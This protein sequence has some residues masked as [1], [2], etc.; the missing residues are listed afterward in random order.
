MEGQRSVI[1]FGVAMKCLSILHYL[2]NHLSV[3]VTSHS[4]SGH[5]IHVKSEVALRVVVVKAFPPGNVFISHFVCKVKKELPVIQFFDMCRLHSLHHRA[6]AAL[7]LK[8][9]ESFV[10]L[11][12]ETIAT[13]AG[14]EATGPCIGMQ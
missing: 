6:P 13:E 3:Y 11:D 5:G 14:M 7:Y 1:Q 8:V 2:T 9:L 10:Q 12:L 4:L